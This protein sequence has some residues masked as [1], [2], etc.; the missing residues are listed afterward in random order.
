M[1]EERMVMVT[2]IKKFWGIKSDS[3]FAG[4]GFGN[5]NQDIRKIL[6]CGPFGINYH[7]E[8]YFHVE[9]VW[10][11][12]NFLKIPYPKDEI[13]KFMVESFELEYMDAKH[14]LAHAY[15]QDHVIL[16]ENIE[17]LLV[18][19]IPHMMDSGKTSLEAARARAVWAIVFYEAKRHKTWLTSFHEHPSTR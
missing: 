3:H 17:K 2:E 7:N 9:G 19:M 13:D 16:L 1:D 6:W 10:E 11:L 12:C 5:L 18:D 15:E 14:H 8:I 4:L